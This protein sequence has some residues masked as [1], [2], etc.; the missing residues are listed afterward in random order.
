MKEFLIKLL[1]IKADGE[2]LS[3]LTYEIN[4]AK[5]ECVKLAYDAALQYSSNH[6][7]IYLLGGNNPSTCPFN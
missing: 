4:N 2:M 6:K 7:I 3:I 1:S 5:D